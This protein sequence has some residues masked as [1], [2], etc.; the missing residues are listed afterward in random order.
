MTSNRLAASSN[1]LCPSDEKGAELVETSLVILLFILMML[2]VFEFGRAYNV[3]QN[4]T[5]AAREGAR[6]A[7]APQRGGGLS[8]P[9]TDQ[10]RAVVVSFLNSANLSD[11]GS[12]NLQV[13]PN[14]SLGG[15]D[16]CNP[17]VSGSPCGTRVSLT[18]PFSIFGFGS[19]NLRTSVTMRNEL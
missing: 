12:T 8:Y 13:L 15:V 14:Q 18:Y 9:T 11:P 6:F 10:V 17:A 4:I 16:P 5:N 7:V 1:K 3:Y 2:G 19:V